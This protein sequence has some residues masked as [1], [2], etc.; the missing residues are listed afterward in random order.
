M[1]VPFGSLVHHSSIQATKVKQSACRRQKGL[2]ATAPPVARD[3]CHDDGGVDSSKV[4][5]SD[6]VISRDPKFSGEGL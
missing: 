6:E 2:G 1:I 3:L 5:L 4:S